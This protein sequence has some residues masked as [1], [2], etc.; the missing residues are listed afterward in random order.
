MQAML[1]GEQKTKLSK[2]GELVA[3]YKVGSS[4]V[5]SKLCQWLFPCRGDYHE[6][7]ESEIEGRGNS[8]FSSS[9]N[10]KLTG[11]MCPGYSIT[12][13]LCGMFLP[14]AC[15]VICPY[16]GLYCGVSGYACVPSK[17][18]TTTIKTTTTT[19]EDIPP[20]MTNPDARNLNVEGK[21]VLV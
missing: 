6:I 10:C 2:I 14:D 1:E 8:D 9:R 18:A 5:D 11:A 19:T 4:T 20:E 17:P 21:V 16:A 3:A 12:C 13:A 7:E 15:G